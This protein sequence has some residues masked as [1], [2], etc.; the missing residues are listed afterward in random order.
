MVHPQQLSREQQ[1]LPVTLGGGQKQ[2]PETKGEQKHTELPCPT[3]GCCQHNEAGLCRAS[4][5]CRADR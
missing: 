3:P 5:R 2:Q 4:P 1:G